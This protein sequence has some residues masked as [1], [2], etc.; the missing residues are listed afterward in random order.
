MDLKASVAQAVHEPGCHRTGLDAQ[1]GV[2]TRMLYNASG[3]CSRISDAYA[4]PK[5][6]T[7]LVTTQIAVVFCDTSS[8][9]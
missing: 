9:T 4:S 2:D 5:L 3:N 6:P 7:L 1:F 8:P